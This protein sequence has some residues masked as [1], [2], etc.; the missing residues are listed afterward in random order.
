MNEGKKPEQ[1]KT[2]NQTFFFVILGSLFLVMLFHDFFLVKSAKVSFSYQLEHLVNLDLLQPEESRK[3]A[4]LSNLV[5]FSGKFRDSKTEVGRQRFRFLELIEEQNQLSRDL[6][7]LEEEML[8]GRKR[9]IN[10]ATL[11]LGVS[12]VPLPPNGY[13]VFSEYY[14][15]PERQNHIIIREIPD[16]ANPTFLSLKK[17]YEAGS[18]GENTEYYLK[19]LQSIVAS[20]RSSLLGIGNEGM[21]KSLRDVDSALQKALLPDAPDQTRAE[22]VQK[23]FSIISSII[24]GLDQAEDHMRLKALR[25]TRDYAKWLDQYAQLSKKLEE[26]SLR[27]ERAMQPV[28][29]QVWFFNNEEI[30]SRLLEKQ[31]PETYHQWF[32]AAKE[33]W[34]LFDGNKEASFKAPDQPLNKVLEKTFKSEELPANYIGYIFSLAPL[35]LVLFL[36]YIAFSKQMKGMGGN[37]MDFNRSPARLY[38]KGSNPVTFKDVAGIDDALEEL[39]EIV[40]FLKAPQKFTAL[41]GKIPKGVLCIG[42]PGTGKTLI[43]RAVAGEADCPFFS[44]SGSDFV[45]MFVG[46]GASRIRKM[47]EEAK[48]NAPCIIFI[49]EIDAVGR[50]RGAGIG[51]G[52]DEREQTLNQLLVEMDGFDTTEGI[53]IVAAT[54]RPDVLDKALLRPGR[55]DRQVIISLPDIKGRFEILKVHA[56][57]IKMDDSVDLMILAKSTPGSSGA[58][59]SNMLNEAALLAARKGREAV[60]MQEI[61]EARDKV[62]YGKE[63]KNLELD[64]Q[65]KR[66]TAYHESGHAVLGSLVEHADPIDKVTIIPRG[67]SLGATQFLPQKNRVTYWRKELIDQLAVLMGGRAAEEIF[68][69]DISNGAKQDIERATQIARS[70][71]CEWGMSESLGTMTYDERSENGNYLGAIGYREKMYSDV[72]AQAIDQ[73]V[74][75]LLDEAYTRAKKLISEHKEII[76][77]M[78]DMLLEFETLD[79]EDIQSIVKNTWNVEEKR[80]KQ[81]AMLERS[82]KVPPPVPKEALAE[83]SDTVVSTS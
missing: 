19:S 76:E 72:T 20:L 8:Q 1:K 36:L 67:F 13:A 51:G 30:S 73:E 25:S 38:P 6:S 64:Q 31:N 75:H 63:R 66:S 29:D 44:I 5:T 56:R 57:N 28:A 35:L 26:N 3:T 15:T 46:V 43:A 37:P 21:K 54:N 33:E 23:A 34:N 17:T 24:S 10:A 80:S 81:K 48:R 27:L 58:D 18:P 60:T 49:D 45:E 9:V 59:L 2:L 12:G 62:L 78:K 53:I 79:A 39:Q 71:V 41:G 11:F 74:R 55:F 50:H 52:H 40:E 4:T 22:T 7:L 61:Y 82:K 14:D 83:K 32:V 69:Q 70:M 77:L 42:P 16:L 68:L 47:F 65:E